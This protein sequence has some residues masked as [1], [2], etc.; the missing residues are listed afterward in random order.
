MRTSWHFQ[1]FIK[2]FGSTQSKAI[3]T[4]QNYLRADWTSSSQTRK[5]TKCTVNGMITDAFLIIKIRLK[6]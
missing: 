3:K 2:E 1:I 6:D 4:S 5:K